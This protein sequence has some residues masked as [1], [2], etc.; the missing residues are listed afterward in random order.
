MQKNDEFFGTLLHVYTRLQAIE[1]GEL[2]DVSSLALEV[3]FK[4]PVAVT[5]AIWDQCIEWTT[6]DSDEQTSQ[7]QSGRLWDVLYV[8]Y[9]A[10][11]HNKDGESC[12][13]YKLN[14]VPRDGVTA[15]A[16]LMRLKAVVAGDNEGKPVITIMFPDED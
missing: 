1:D 14:V 13:H 8:L 9:L 10:C 12:T 16:K 2:V 15:K 5:R 6:E 7:D 3:G 11:K 4:I